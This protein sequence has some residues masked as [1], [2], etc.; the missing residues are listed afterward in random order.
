MSGDWGLFKSTLYL[1]WE[2]C[3]F[4]HKNEPKG[5]LLHDT[6]SGL[7]ELIFCQIYQIVPP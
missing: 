2:Y 5:V 7:F 4:S 3:S 1:N 6:D